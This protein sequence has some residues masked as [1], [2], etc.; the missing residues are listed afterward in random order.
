VP[1]NGAQSAVELQPTKQTLMSALLVMHQV[2]AP[3]HSSEL[4]QI[5]V[6]QLP[7]QVPVGPHGASTVVHG[8]PMS[9][10]NSG[11]AQAVPPPWSVTQQLVPQS[12]ALAQRPAQNEPRPGKSTHE[13]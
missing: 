3:G 6:H 7:L 11:N 12:A 9:M 10:Q 8:S 2:S 5:I 4:A 1:G 13:A